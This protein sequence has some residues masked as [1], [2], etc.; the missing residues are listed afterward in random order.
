MRHENNSVAQ[1]TLLKE[2]WISFVCVHLLGFFISSFNHQLDI[3]TKFPKDENNKGDDNMEVMEWEESKIQELR[4]WEKLKNYYNIWSHGHGWTKTISK[5]PVFLGFLFSSPLHQYIFH[6]VSTKRG[7]SIFYHKGLWT[8]SHMSAGQHTHTQARAHTTQLNC[9]NTGLEW[10]KS[11]LSISALRLKKKLQRKKERRPSIVSPRR[12]RLMGK[13]TVMF[14]SKGW[15]YEEHIFQIITHIFHGYRLLAIMS[16]TCIT[17]NTWDHERIS[18]LVGMIGLIHVWIFSECDKLT[19]WWRVFLMH[20]CTTFSTGISPKETP[21][22]WLV[23]GLNSKC[24]FWI[25]ILL[26]SFRRPDGPWRT[27][28]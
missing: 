3:L 5:K 11:S 24:P 15:L 25:F 2:Q 17:C 6:W 18:K 20:T 10:N 4:K 27:N 9:F 23:G 13:K 12:G 22:F 26:F 19:F 21:C 14:L 7:R 28:R 8:H 1:L 16:W